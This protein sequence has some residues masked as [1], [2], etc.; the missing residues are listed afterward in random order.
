[1]IL[2]LVSHQQLEVV[3]SVLENELSFVKKNQAVTITSFVDKSKNYMGVV[4]EINPMVDENGLIQVKAKV[5]IPDNTLFDGMNVKV[6]INQP[7]HDVIVI[8]K[9]ALV[10]RSNKEV[11]FTVKEGL[12]KWN[13]VE[14]LDENSSS[15]AL[16]K[17][18]K[19]G[20]TIIVSGNMNL[21]HDARVAPIFIGEQEDSK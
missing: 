20:D 15:Y 19:L 10:L 8:P 7:I 3:F 4:S 5:N 17:G 12:A 11:V 18:L 9:E 21:S 6:I 16:K 2:I 14:V 1:M 13:Y